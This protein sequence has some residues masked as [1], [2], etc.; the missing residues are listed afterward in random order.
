MAASNRS[1]KFSNVPRVVVV[2]VL[3]WAA[4]EGSRDYKATESMECAG[5]G[6]FGELG[7]AHVST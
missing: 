2:V 7:A 3:E 4:N 1:A 6:V 5:I